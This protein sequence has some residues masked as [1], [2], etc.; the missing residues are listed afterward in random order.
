[1]ITVNPFLH[2]YCETRNLPPPSQEDLQSCGRMISHHFK[3]YWAINFEE[4]IIPDTGFL[5]TIEGDKKVV[6]HG[7]PDLFKTEMAKRIDLYFSQKNKPKI[8]PELT[9]QP[10]LEISTPPEPKKER[11][12]KPIPVKIGS[13]KPQNESGQ[14]LGQS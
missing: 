2:F 1:M 9:S 6:V 14:I 10:K 11:K 12:R 7:Y 8:S 3:N 13:F 4:G 5:V